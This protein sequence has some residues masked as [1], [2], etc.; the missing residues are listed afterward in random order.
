M[1]KLDEIIA[2][3]WAL[4]QIQNADEAALHSLSGMEDF[5]AFTSP[6][7]ADRRYLLELVHDCRTALQLI[8][9]QTVCPALFPKDT[10]EDVICVKTAMTIAMVALEKINA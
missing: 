1:S 10:D 9:D 5:K 4:K 8:A 2:R 3:D 6:Q 7:E